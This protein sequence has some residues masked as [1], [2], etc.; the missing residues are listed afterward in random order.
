MVMTNLEN[1]PLLLHVCCAPCASA[2]VER[3][4]E[5]GREIRLYYSNSNITTKEEFER[6]CSYVEVR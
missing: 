2:C 5:T 3:L 4:L 1:T 6:L